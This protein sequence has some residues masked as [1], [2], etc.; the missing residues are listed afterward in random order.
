MNLSL[1]RSRIFFGEICQFLMTRINPINWGDEFSCQTLFVFFLIIQPWSH[2]WDVL[3]DFKCCKNIKIYIFYRR[4]IK[5]FLSHHDLKDSFRMDLNKQMTHNAIFHIPSYKY[6]FNN[7]ILIIGNFWEMFLFSKMCK[8]VFSKLLTNF[9]LITWSYFKI[10]IP[11]F[12]SSC[13]NA[14]V[15]KSKFSA[16]KSKHSQ[17]IFNYQ[18]KWFF[19]NRNTHV[20]KEKEIF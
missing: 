3:V 13:W 4:T 20:K 19:F 7:N 18:F 6:L 10:L 2:T 12:F 15:I 17:F 11:V 8:N 9:K 16:H 1:V 5:N 14:Q